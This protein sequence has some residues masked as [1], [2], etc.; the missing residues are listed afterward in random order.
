M[1]S[2]RDKDKI[3]GFQ[4]KYRNNDVLLIDDIQF[5]ENKEA[6]QEEFFHTFNTLYE[7]N[8][9]IIIS[10]DRPPK[11]IATLE[12][13]LRSRFE[14]GLITDI[15]P[16]DLE[17]RIAILRK[18]AQ[19]EN[20]RAPDDVMQFIASKIQSNIRELEGSLIRIVAFSSLTKSPI[21]LNL[22]KDVLKDIISNKESK[23]I[24]IKEI[25]DKICNYFNI[26]T[27]ELVGNKRSQSI[28]YPR[29]I[30]MYLSRELTDFSLP[31]I[32]EEFGGRDHTTVMHANNK[33]KNLINQHRETYNQ[34]QELTNLIKQNN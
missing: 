19:L 4:N 10:S 22:A 9:Q 8:K 27:N 20:L 23:Q 29:Q 2:I 21:D 12:D 25:Q 32:G 5:L 13:R 28:V 7:S 24:T 11:D 34:I 31:K 26:S 3:V 30:A 14:W 15:Q 33:V 17:T 6:T 1:N 18:T 16:P